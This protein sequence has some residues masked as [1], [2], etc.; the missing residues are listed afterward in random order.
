MA[1]LAHLTIRP[2]A[3]F[4]SITVGSTKHPNI[5]ESEGVSYRFCREIAEL[6]H[7]FLI[8]PHFPQTIDVV[9]V[10]V[11]IFRKYGDSNRAARK[12]LTLFPATILFLM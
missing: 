2:I 5:N 8:Q 3:I 12:P 11:W 9:I 4:T 1:T 10:L 6:K 7:D